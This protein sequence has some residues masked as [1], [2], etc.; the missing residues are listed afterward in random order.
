MIS[1]ITLFTLAL[2]VWAQRGAGQNMR[3]GM[4]T[5]NCQAV[6]SSIPKQDL[7]ATEIEQLT[8]MREEEK[9]ARDVY[10]E[11]YLQ[12]GTP[13]FNNISQSEQRHFDALQV[14]LER[15]GL[16]DPAAN[17]KRGYFQNS[18]LQQLYSDLVSQ[19]SPSLSAAL[20]VGA[21]IEDL[22]IRDLQKAL[23]ATDN[24]DL[25]AVYQNLKQGSEN[26][27]RAFVGRLQAIDEGYVAQYISAAELA[28][29][30]VKA[31]NSGNGYGRGSRQRRLGQANCADCF[32]R[33][34]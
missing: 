10:T 27:L 32:G 21:T 20:R 26:H 4:E 23:A 12:W 9:L 31:D 13:I 25:K 1:A 24:Q 11:L 6:I 29:I 17:S 19:G 7:D 5:C 16:P 34:P 8:F 3:H 14:L 15:Y 33:N 18:E 2:P 28:E 30:L 22:D